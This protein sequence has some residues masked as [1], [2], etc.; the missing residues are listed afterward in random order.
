MFNSITGELTG[1][2]F[3]YLYISTHGVEWQVEVSAHSFRDMLARDA[4]DEVQVLVHLYVREDIL[5]LYGF[6]SSAERAA[7]LQLI[8]VS[9]IGPKQALKILSGISADQ[10]VA[11]LEAEDV[12]ALTRLPGIGTKSAQKM[13]LQLKGHLVTETTASSGAA[14]GATGT[15]SDLLQGL[16]EMGFDRSR[17]EKAL[18]TLTAVLVDEGITDPGEQER[19]L[20]ARAIRELS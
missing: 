19:Q 13:I 7:Y 12:G 11:L 8:T 9:G 1:H 3:P 17:A 5:K 15:G 4:G 16:V 10:L 18:R 14:S 2:Q 20:F 6:S